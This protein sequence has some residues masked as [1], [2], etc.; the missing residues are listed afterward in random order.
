MKGPDVKSPL[1]QI[2]ASTPLPP[3]GLQPRG[4]NAVALGGQR[5]GGVQPYNPTKMGAG[6]PPGGQDP[7]VDAIMAMM[8]GGGA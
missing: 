5:A 4:I 1:N 3:V 6:K 7:R 8:Q 2:Q